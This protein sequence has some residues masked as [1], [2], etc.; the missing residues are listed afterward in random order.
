MDMAISCEQCLNKMDEN[1]PIYIC[2]ECHEDYC[3]EN[4]LNKHLA[5]NLHKKNT[6]NICITN[7]QWLI[8]LNKNNEVD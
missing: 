3:S 2:S 7:P 6:V 5:Q 8:N 4:C 1:A